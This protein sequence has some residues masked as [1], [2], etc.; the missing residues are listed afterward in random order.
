VKGLFLS[1]VI[2]VAAASVSAFTIQQPEQKP[3][4]DFLILGAVAKPGI[5]AWRANLTVRQALAQAGGRARDA[6]P[7]A[8]FFLVPPD[9]KRVPAQMDDVLKPQDALF[10]PKAQQ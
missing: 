4:A 7:V 10:V 8:I 6:D 1:A 9:K 5:Y 3:R 2:A